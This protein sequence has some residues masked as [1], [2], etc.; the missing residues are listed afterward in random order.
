M[1]M[2]PS[3]LRDRKKKTQTAED[4]S[5]VRKKKQLANRRRMVAK[6]QK[7]KQTARGRK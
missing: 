2:V 6:R 3:K 4:K 1:A 5:M 7:A